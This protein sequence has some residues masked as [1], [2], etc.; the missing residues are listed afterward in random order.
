MTQ[1]EPKQPKTSQN[2]LKGDL[3]RARM[4]QNEPKQPKS[5]QNEP[6]GDLK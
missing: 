2:E 4:T 1:N 6:K 5:S 3:T